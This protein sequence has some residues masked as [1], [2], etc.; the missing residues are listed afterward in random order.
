VQEEAEERDSTEAIRIVI[1]VAGLAFNLWIMLDPT[2]R[3][4]VVRRVQ[5][6]WVR[7]VSGPEAR[8]KALRKAEAETV[9]EAL[10]IV[11]G[12]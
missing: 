7:N 9:F 6:W 4:I 10:T 2:K 11:E 3:E 1:M 12:V 5:G 8:V